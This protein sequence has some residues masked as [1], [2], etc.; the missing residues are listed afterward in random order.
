MF[1]L[2]INLGTSSQ[3]YLNSNLRFK[4]KREEEENEIK[5]KRLHLAL[6]TNF[7][8]PAHSPYSRSPVLHP[9]A[10]LRQTLAAMWAHV[11]SHTP[12]ART[13]WARCTWARH[14]HCPWVPLLS[15]T[16]QPFAW[17]HC[18]WVPLIGTI[19]SHRIMANLWP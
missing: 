18:P 7:F 14:C 11:T 17:P 10:R 2:Y 16:F 6:W 9:C 12:A 15:F 4:F 8:S 19:F 5:K 1:I 13:T 3:H